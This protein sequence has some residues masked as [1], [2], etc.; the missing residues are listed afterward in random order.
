MLC[1]LW[2]TCTP[3]HVMF[4]I[5]LVLTLKLL[6]AYFAN[7]KWCKKAEKWLKQWP[8]CIHLLVLRFCVFVP[9]MKV[10][11]ANGAS[12]NFSRSLSM[13]RPVY[14]WQSFIVSG[15]NLIKFSTVSFE[16]RI[17]KLNTKRISF[18]RDIQVAIKSILFV[19]QIL[20]VSIQYSFLFDM[21]LFP[22][23]YQ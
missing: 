17:P 3:C 20:N 12:F 22:D 8:I 18:G 4:V 14:L 16:K 21:I 15:W 5:F 13:I 23:Q 2:I 7:T 10:T 1:Y 9:R 11:S 6:V 19:I